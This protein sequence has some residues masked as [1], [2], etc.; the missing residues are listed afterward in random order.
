MPN[1]ARGCCCCR[2]SGADDD[3]CVDDEEKEGEED[4]GAEKMPSCCM[5]EA[6][7]PPNEPEVAAA[8]AAEEGLE[9]ADAARLTLS[10]E[11][12][13]CAFSSLTLFRP[14]CHAAVRAA[15]R[16]N[17]EEARAYGGAEDKESVVVRLLTV[18]ATADKQPPL[19]LLLLLLL[20]PQ[21]APDKGDLVEEDRERK[22]A[23]CVEAALMCVDVV[24]SVVDLGAN[25]DGD[26][27]HP[28]NSELRVVASA[29]HDRSRADNIRF[30]GRDRRAN[31][32]SIW[33]REGKEEKRVL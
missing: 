28:V 30:C 20:L 2:C 15:G 16:M 17:E 33:V 25:G 24:S 8:A 27:L 1:A 3:D 32:E 21:I 29:R 12:P 7:A 6:A 10:I 18:E 9:V 5:S 31:H 14:T 13:R 4:G 11:A 19:A 26:G 22:R 23:E